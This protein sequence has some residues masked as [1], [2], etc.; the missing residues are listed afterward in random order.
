MQQRVKAVL[1]SIESME[2]KEF[3]AIPTLKT[4]AFLFNIF[5]SQEIN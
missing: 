4:R 1:G 2:L 5:R 3:Q